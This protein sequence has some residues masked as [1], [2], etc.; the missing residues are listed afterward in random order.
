MFNFHAFGRLKIFTL[1]LLQIE[2]NKL[3]ESTTLKERIIFIL[4]KCCIRQKIQYIL[5]VNS[6]L[7]SSGALG[8]LGKG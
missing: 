8:C 1:K 6:G 7:S 2:C 5:F 4:K 3:L